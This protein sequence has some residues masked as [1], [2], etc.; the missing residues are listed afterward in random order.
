MNAINIAQ[1]QAEVAALEARGI[2]I[3]QLYLLS[4]V[5]ELNVNLVGE[6]AFCE[7]LEEE[8]NL[9]AN[10]DGSGCY[11]LVNGLRDDLHEMRV[12]F[13]AHQS[14]QPKSVYYAEG[15]GAAR[16]HGPNVN[17]YLDSSR[18]G[19]EWQQGYDHAMED[20]FHEDMADLDSDI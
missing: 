15:Y 4:T 10:L 6:D 8:I 13:E 7:S 2:N 17:R 9:N 16:N 5:Q 3:Y 1:L 12:A 18:L 19:Q 20:M 14:T 11:D